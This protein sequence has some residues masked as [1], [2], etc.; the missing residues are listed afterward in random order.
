MKNKYKVFMAGL[1]AGA[2]VYAAHRANH[3]IGVQHIACHNHKVPTAFDGFRI[4]QVA[5]LHNANF[6]MKQHN[7]LKHCKNLRP[8][9]IVITGDLIDRLKTTKEN[10]KHTRRFIFEA[11]KIAPVYFVPGNHEAT[12]ALY[13]YVKQYL[14]DMG[15]IILDNSK[16][17]LT[18]NEDS[19]SILGLKDPK[20][21]YYDKTKFMKNLDALTETTETNF[22]ILL[23]HR[24]EKFDAYVKAGFNLVFCGHAHGGQ[25]RL[26]YVGGLFA[27]NQGFFPKYTS[28]TFTSG[29]TTMIVSRGMGNSRA[30]LRICNHPELI[31]VEL[32][33]ESKENST[34][35]KL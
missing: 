29:E 8:D 6:G 11:V 30:P 9:C 15:V 7:L 17:E 5:D 14:S 19:I 16:I 27:P 20:F 25:I 35:E 28:G 2:L 4:V 23:S 18:K 3:K 33:A 32:H 21:Y 10:M 22:S 26:P 31:C 13:P 1:G 34:N 24:P 12:S